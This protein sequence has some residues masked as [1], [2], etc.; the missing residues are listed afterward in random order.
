MSAF[1]PETWPFSLDLLPDEAHLVGG[2]VRDRLLHR[3]SAYLDLDFVLPQDAVKTASMIAR[4]CDAGF[5][6][7]DQARQIARVVFEQ[8]TVDFA[9]QQGDSLEADL[10]RRDFTVNAIAYHPHSQTLID[11]LEGKADIA[12]KT[13]RMVS[14]ENL[15]ADPLRLMRA[16]R[17]AAQLGFTLSPATQS[18][19]NQL[20]PHLAAISIER[21]R[22]ELDALLSVPVG[23]DQLTPILHSQLLQFC[24]PHFNASNI[25]QIAAIDQATEQLTKDLPAY[26]KR[27]RGWLKPVP[28]GFYRSWIK[29]T[30][31][32]RLIGQDEATAEADLATLKYS[33][34]EAQVALTLVKLQPEIEMIHREPLSQAQQFFLFKAAGESFP[35]VSLLGLAQGVSMMVLQPMIKRFLDLNDPVAHPQVLITGRTLIKRLGMKPGP[36]IGN[37][38][39]AVEL[40]QANGE[41]NDQEEAIAWV[42]QL[43]PYEFKP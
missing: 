37:L 15:A 16:Y 12:S 35:A 42:K 41:I 38:L 11:P 18:A 10:R 2:S 26:V 31:L 30:K 1:T 40:A 21:V 6:V 32:S 25:E 8:M 17:Q 24:L 20:S 4:S 13:I 43:K 28:A 22:Q 23:T 34:T 3:Q 29:V 9:Q 7:L 27:L 14:Y 39:K 33:R 36:E 5:V 19:I